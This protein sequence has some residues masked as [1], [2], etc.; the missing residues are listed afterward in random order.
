MSDKKKNPVVKYVFIFVI[1]LIVIGSGIRSFRDYASNP[2][3]FEKPEGPRKYEYIA[4]FVLF[5]GEHKVIE[6]NGR[7]LIYRA[8]KTINGSPKDQ[9]M[10]V[11]AFL[12]SGRRIDLDYITRDKVDLKYTLPSYRTIDYLVFYVHEDGLPESFENVRLEN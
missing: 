8:S 6:T 2:E 5:P 10:S 11:F 3:N 9:H 1:V 12:K 4:D 7:T